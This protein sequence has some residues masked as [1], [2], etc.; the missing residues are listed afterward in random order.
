MAFRKGVRAARKVAERNFE[1]DHRWPDIHETLRYEE[2]LPALGIMVADRIKGER[3]AQCPLPSHPG[4]DSNP[5]FSVNVVKGKFNCFTCSTGGSVPYLVELVEDFDDPEDAIQFLIPFSDYEADEDAAFVQQISKYLD[6]K[7][8]PRAP[9]ERNLPYFPDRI[10]LP[11]VD[12]ET[13]YYRNRFIEDWARKEL[14][15]GY[16]HKRRRVG[17]D[18]IGPAALI[19][20]FFKGKLVGYQER[21]LEPDEVAEG[22]YHPLVERPD[23]LRKYMATPDF[24][25]KCT[26]YNYDMAAEMCQDAPIFVVESAMTVARLLSAGY[27]AVATFGASV[28]DEQLRLLAGFPHVV[29]AYDND[30]AGREATKAIVK[31]MDRIANVEVIPPPEGNKGDL[32]DLDDDDLHAQI[33]LS[34]PG[35]MW[36]SEH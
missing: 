19:P 35:F 7:P 13:A 25:K 20:H 9:R 26:L 1:E 33:G 6:R 2:L 3:I 30:D 32:G 34:E 21:W 4:Q 28:N 27:I 16:D 22:E 18:Y 29:V 15:L 17:H 12:T 31:H 24:P 14:K 36:L 8:E 5:S 10:V 11:Y 23:S